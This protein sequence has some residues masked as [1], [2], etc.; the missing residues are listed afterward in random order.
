M[1]YIELTC[2][3]PE[4]PDFLSDLLADALNN[5]GYE[6]FVEAE[7]GLKAYIPQ[8]KFSA[9]ALKAI[10][11]SDLGDFSITFEH[12]LMEDKNWNEEWEKNFFEPLLIANKCLIRST[13][14]KTDQ[15]AEYEI[16][17][18]PKMSFGTGHHQ[19][20]SLMISHILDLKLQDKAVLD[21]GCGTGVLAILAAMRGAA[22]ILAI[23]IDEWAYNNTLENISIN[24]QEQIEVVK[25]GAELLDKQQFDAVFAN[26]NRNILL[27]DIPAYVRVMKSGATLLLSGF[28][29]DD[30]SF[31]QE[32]CQK[33][34]LSI[35]N[36]LTKDKWVA[37]RL[38]KQ[39][40]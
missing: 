25:G 31:I 10:D 15:Q 17:I 16:L 35:I 11:F 7:N 20:T 4:E 28:Y 22:S 26:I 38:I 30:I 8:E 5:L 21:M 37:L 27:E 33:N 18:D 6:S 34:K 40:N 3:M 9:E 39:T 36:Q 19:T 32:V 24:K 23:D 2:T 12:Q 29:T 1:Q 13:F 14:H